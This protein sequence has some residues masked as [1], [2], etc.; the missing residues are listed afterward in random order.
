MDLIA[1]MG[2]LINPGTIK[3]YRLVSIGFRILTR[4]SRCHEFISSTLSN[5]AFSGTK[6]LTCHCPLLELSNVRCFCI[7][8]TGFL[9][10]VII[11][12][13]RKNYFFYFSIFIYFYVL[14]L[15]FCI[16]IRIFVI[17]IIF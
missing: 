8:L 12:G 15:I 9:V 3:R 1:G 16:N 14:I 11:R 2:K 4:G 17:M 13:R 6:L 10:T 7:D 5:Q